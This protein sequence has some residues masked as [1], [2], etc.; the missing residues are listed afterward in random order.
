MEFFLQIVQC[1]LR[2]FGHF[3]FPSFYPHWVSNQASIQTLPPKIQTPTHA[4]MQCNTE[5][6]APQSMFDGYGLG[7]NCYLCFSISPPFVPWTLNSLWCRHGL[8]LQQVSVTCRTCFRSI[9]H[10]AQHPPTYIPS[11]SGILICHP[12]LPIRN[13]DLQGGF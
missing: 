9:H 10:L 2:L 12:T 13:S 11:A 7:R 3:G 4:P 1:I 6:S 8:H 5:V